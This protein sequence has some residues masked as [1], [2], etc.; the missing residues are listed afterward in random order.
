[1]MA[2]RSTTV[3]REARTDRPTRMYNPPHPGEILRDTVPG[4]SGLSVSAF[5]KPRPKVER[6]TPA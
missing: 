1:M 6:V 5:R 2:T 4:E 3:G